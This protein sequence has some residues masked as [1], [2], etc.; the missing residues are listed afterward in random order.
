MPDCHPRSAFLNEKSD[1]LPPRLEAAATLF[2]WFDHI[3][4]QSFSAV[5]QEFWMK[6][7]QFFLK[8]VQNFKLPHVT[9]YVVTFLGPTKDQPMFY[10]ETISDHTG[11]TSREQWKAFHRTYRVLS[12]DFDKLNAQAHFQ[13][14]FWHDD[15]YWSWYWV[16]EYGSVNG[17]EGFGFPRNHM[18]KELRWRLL[19]LAKRREDRK[20]RRR[21][22][23]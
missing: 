4:A 10:L 15:R 8:L 23:A 16:C 17:M 22:G 19:D 18:P 13:C 12:R 2:D 20:W 9:N 6:K 3:V 21:V 14:I 11:P 5:K 1:P 7:N